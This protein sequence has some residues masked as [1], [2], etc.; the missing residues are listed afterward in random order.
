M[1]KEIFELGFSQVELGHGIRVSL[2]EGIEQFLGD[3]PMIVSSLHNFCP[4]PIEIT[5]PAPDCY[6]CTSERPEERQRALRHTLQTI[7]KAARLK[8]TKVVLHLGSVDLPDYT[9][10]L[11]DRIRDGGYLDRK[12]VAIKLKAIQEREATSCYDRVIE[13]LEPVIEHAKTAGV[14]LGIENRIGVE[15]F[16]SEKEFDRLFSQ[17][18][19]GSIGYWHDFGH[20]Q[21]RHNLTFL[22]H[23]EWLT[24]FLP[25]I[26]GCHVHDVKFPVRDHQAPFSG[27]IEFSNLVPLLPAGIPIVWEM[28]SRVTK[29]EIAAALAQWTRLEEGDPI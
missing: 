27:M 13:W 26:V 1:L 24:H 21:V 19:D 28:S 15:T 10:R 29:Q 6:Q 4:L 8:V 7:D 16:P 14:T 9:Q 17:Y 3:H 2:W 18:S 11:A 5:R 12:Y 25:R 23:R 20:A 22:D